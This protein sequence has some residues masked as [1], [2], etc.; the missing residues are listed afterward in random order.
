[1]KMVKY[2]ALMVFVASVLNCS[3][4][5]IR[6]ENFTTNSVPALVDGDD[7]FT[8]PPGITDFSFYSTNV[9]VNINADEG[10]VC[11]DGYGFADDAS[12]ILRLSMRYGDVRAHLFAVTQNNPPIMIA[13]I[14]GFE[15]KQLAYAGMGA[16]GL[17][18]AGFCYRRKAQR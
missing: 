1:M 3:A 16:L 17:V 15:N 8:F 7:T 6:V 11:Q 9:N 10:W 12:V 18:F 4:V 14:P 5:S 2:V 13:W